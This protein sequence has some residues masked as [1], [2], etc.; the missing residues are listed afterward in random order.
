MT[1]K[2]FGWTKSAFSSNLRYIVYNPTFH[3]GIILFFCLNIYLKIDVEAI[4]KLNKNE[5]CLQ[6][7]IYQGIVFMIMLFTCFK[8]N[9]SIEIKN[10][11]NVSR[12]YVVQIYY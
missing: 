1:I 10:A 4:S 8:N 9:K 5:N 6:I 3:G 2:Y 7:L 11:I 12:Y